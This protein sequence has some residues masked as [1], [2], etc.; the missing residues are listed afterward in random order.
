LLSKGQL[1][2]QFTAVTYNCTTISYNVY[3]MHTYMRSFLNKHAC[4]IRVVNYERNIFIRFAFSRC[5]KH[6]LQQRC[7]KGI[8]VEK[9]N[10]TSGAT[11]LAITTLCT[12]TLSIKTLGSM[13][14]GIMTLDDD[15]CH[16]DH[17]YDNT[18]HN[19]TW[20]NDTRHND[21][22]HSLSLC[23]CPQC[24]NSDCRFA[25]WNSSS[26]SNIILSK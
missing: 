22:Q 3:F 9:V 2:K 7:S 18:Q 19:D 6:F 23:F 15:T 24:H 26:L 10:S 17:W 21:T 8:S 16:N 1:Y 4:A 11:T 5:Q 12:M 25:E 14:L 20:H 13:T